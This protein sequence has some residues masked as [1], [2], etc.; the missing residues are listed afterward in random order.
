MSHATPPKHPHK[1]RKRVLKPKHTKFVTDASI[2]VATAIAGALASYVVTLADT[3]ERNHSAHG[4]EGHWLS[5][6]CARDTRTRGNMV[7]DALDIGIGY[8]AGI[9]F[10]NADHRSFTYAGTGDIVDQRYFFGRWRS[11]KAGATANG[12]FQFSISDQ[13]DYMAGT[14]TGNDRAGNYVECW[15]LGRDKAALDAAREFLGQQSLYP[16]PKS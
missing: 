15:L 9:H 14:F 2:F 10:E 3:Y 5:S 12:T 6:S 1:P 7:P 13:G 8:W 11:T 4:I 16:A